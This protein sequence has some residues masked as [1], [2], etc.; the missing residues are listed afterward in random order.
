MHFLGIICSVHEITIGFPRFVASL[1]KNESVLR[2]VNPAFRYCK[3]GNYLLI[4]IDSNRSF[5]EMFSDF[6]GSDG[7]I[8]TGISAGEPGRID[9]CNWDCTVIRIK[10]FQSIFEEK[11]KV[12]G[13]DTTKKF[14]ECS[15]VRD[16]CET[17]YSPDAIHLFKVPYD[18]T[19][20]FFPV[21]FEK[22][23]GQ[24]LVLSI[25]SS[26]IFAGIQGDPG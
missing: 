2:V 20:I 8:M 23:D 16:R 5:Q 3:S 13:F 21:F 14:L 4:G 15:E 22:K 24:K 6:S 26:R 1:Q 19:I 18:R 11:I 25:I 9:G 17:Q 7:V 10:Q 12:H